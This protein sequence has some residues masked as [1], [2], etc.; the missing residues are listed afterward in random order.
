MKLSYKKRV[1]IS[2]FVIFAVFSGLVIYVEQKEE[3]R[4]RTEA[5]ESELEDYADIIH[6]YV[7]LHALN[8]TNIL[9]IHDLIAVMPNEVRVT[10]LEPDGKVSF[11]REVKDVSVLE[12]HKNRPEILKAQYQ[13]EG[14]DIR[15]STSV[16]Q[17][18]L[19]YAKAYQD[20]YVRVALPYNVE[21]QSLMKADN[22][23]I[24]IVLFLFVMVLLLLN[25]AVSRFGKS[26]TELKQ[27][28]TIV[29]D[30][31]PLPKEVD[32]PHDEL[33]SIGNELVEIFNQRENDRKVL[34]VE[35]EK[36]IRHFKYS[37]E[38]FVVFSKDKKPQFSNS[39]FIQYLNHIVDQPAL[40]ASA[41]FRE[42]AF[43]PVADFVDNLN[44]EKKQNVFQIN[45]N[46]KSFVVQTVMY[47][48]KTFEVSIRDITQAEKTRLIKQEMTNN[49][50][51]ELRTP[52]TSM[53]GYLETL[54]STELSEEKRKQFIDR[55][56]VQSVRLSNLIEDVG[57]LSK[58]EEPA[59]RFTFDKV[60]LASIVNEVR[61]DLADKLEQNSI[62]LNVT[63]KDG[64]IIK[65]NHSLL[66]SIFRNLIDNSIS[67]GGESTAIYIDNY[68]EDEKFVYFSYYD[69][70]KGV[71]EKLLPR[72]FE[73]FY[74]GDEGRTR[75]NGASGLGLAIV[76]NS[77][78]VHRG[79]IQVKNKLGAGLEFLFT[80]HK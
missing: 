75:E 8:D 54:V 67:Y 77:V 35:R 53:R 45:K 56:Y 57:L 22:M 2:F 62:K 3:K 16:H 49:I 38:G 50:A 29:K 47:D 58:I 43:R 70:G 64:L 7:K 14:T 17:P 72:I 19:Y 76:R 79:E 25:Y 48:D 13:G 66:Y 4:Y 10:I 28:S 78:M 11:D 32:F 36:L 23:F 44:R 1:F 61:I 71:D 51:H 55:A 6:N 41:I 5:L 74:R 65:G 21:V 33:G 73:R 24:Y 34:E 69:T 52:V 31:K 12:N 15:L 26:I 40:D 39:H 59:S 27:F 30:N 37:A 60:D 42:E 63:V 9:Q 18:F 20:C 80:L 68:L 46:G